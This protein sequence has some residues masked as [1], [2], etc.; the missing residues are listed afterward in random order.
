MMV[1]DDSTRS[2]HLHNKVAFQTKDLGHNNAVGDY[3]PKLHRSRDYG[4]DSYQKLH[5]ISSLWDIE[6][7]FN[8]PIRYI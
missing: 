2:E 8:L 3:A 6:A 5:N 7:M 1:L 4:K